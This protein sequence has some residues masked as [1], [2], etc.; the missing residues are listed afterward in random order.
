VPLLKQELLTLPKNLSSPPV[1]SWVRATRSLAWCVCFLDRFFSFYTFSF[2]HCVV[3]SSSIYRFWLPL[4]YLQTL[5][6]LFMIVILTIKKG[7]QPSVLLTEYNL[8][9]NMGNISIVFFKIFIQQ[10]D[11]SRIIAILHSLFNLQMN[12]I[13]GSHKSSTFEYNWYLQIKFE[14]YNLN[15]F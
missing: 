9:S 8:L 7:F 15:L 5:L 12:A 3:C 14:N 10:F 1:L 2:G 6:T 11:I 13:F 4:W